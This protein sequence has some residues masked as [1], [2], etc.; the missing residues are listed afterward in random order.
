MNV[1]R[2]G[3]PTAAFGL[4]GVRFLT[5]PTF[6]PPGEYPIGTRTL[7]KTQPGRRLHIRSKRVA[8]RVES[9]VS[10]LPSRSKPAW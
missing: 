10:P 8:A 4:G 3:G 7:T 9:S 1:Q 6:D 5:D 2:F